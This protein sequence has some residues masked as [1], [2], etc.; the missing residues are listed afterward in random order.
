MN[1]A[2]TMYGIVLVLLRF[3]IIRKTMKTLALREKCANAEF[4]LVQIREN[5]DQKE[6]RI[7]TLFTHC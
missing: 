5:T 2:K 6:L 4:F 1:V 3:Q 7:W